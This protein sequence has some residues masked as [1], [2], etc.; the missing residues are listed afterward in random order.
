MDLLFIGPLTNLALALRLSPGIEAGIN[1]LTIMGGTV[2]GRGNTTPAAEFNVFADPEA[3]A[4]V[5]AADVPTT[6]VPWEPCTL[7]DVPGAELDAAFAA[8]PDD[9]YGRFAQGLARHAR[10]VI[11]GYGGGDV[12]H[13]VDHFAAALVI[14]PS[15]VTASVTAS[16]DVALAPGI[17]RGMTVVDPSGRLGTPPVTLVEAADLDGLKALFA[18]S[19]SWRPGA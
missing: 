13:L 18:A 11:A 12:L 19:V 14:D 3:A 5:F 2:F 16:V 9:A 17:T 10:A 15:L 8:A 7:H 1:H 4:I 6:V